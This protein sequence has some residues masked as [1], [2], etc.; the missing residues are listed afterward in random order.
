MDLGISQAICGSGHYRGSFRMHTIRYI[1][2]KKKDSGGGRLP[3]M[4]NEI[5]TDIEDKGMSF[6]KYK[7]AGL[8]MNKIYNKTK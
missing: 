8:K 6:C 5:A 4:V 2:T 1:R 3:A 7:V